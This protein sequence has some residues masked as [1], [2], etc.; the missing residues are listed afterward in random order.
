MMDI[1]NGCL[2]KILAFDMVHRTHVNIFLNH[3]ANSEYGKREGV[4]DRQWG[5][6]PAEFA[7]WYIDDWITRIY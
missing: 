6:Y 1:Q 3:T 4:S 2:G 5:Y 7:N